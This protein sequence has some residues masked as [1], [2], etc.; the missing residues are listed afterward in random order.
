[1]SN[2]LKVE[3]KCKKELQD[4]VKGAFK[5]H[6]FTPIVPGLPKIGMFRILISVLLLFFA[7][8]LHHDLSTSHDK[9]HQKDVKIWNFV[10]KYEFIVQI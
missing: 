1:M 9:L 4:K 6:P 3:K 5:L 10:R 8:F 2:G 7:K